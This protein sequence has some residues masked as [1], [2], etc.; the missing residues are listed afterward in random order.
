V[1]TSGV[2]GPGMKNPSLK[3]HNC[4]NQYA[5]L[6]IVGLTEMERLRARDLRT[7]LEVAR[8]LGAVADVDRFRASL[9]LQLKRLVPYDIASWNVVSPG[10]REAQIGAV[11]PADCRENDDE[12]TLGAYLHQNPLVAPADPTQVVKFSDFITLRQLHRLE[13]YDA[14]YRRLAVEHQIAF[15]LPAPRSS[16]I[17]VVLS[18]SRPDFTERDRSILAAAKPIVVQAYEHA[19][20]LAL[21]RGMLSALEHATDAVEHAIIVLHPSGHI[22]FATHAAKAS[23]SELSS[24][25]QPGSLPEPLASWSEAQS[26]RAGAVLPFVESLTFRTGTARFMRG[27]VGG[28]DAIV[29]ERSGQLSAST[30]RA[31]GLTKRQAEVL[32]LVALGLTNTQIALE[33]ALSERTVAKHLEHIYA[34]LGVANRTAA[35]AW[36]RD[37]RAIDERVPPTAP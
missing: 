17:G 20:T 32:A 31:A 7:V 11:D 8:Q 35:V 25:D 12:E 19:V 26:R 27:D 10:S 28:F 34:K 4:C 15:L 1:P 21:M 6:R 24:P 13:L 22:Q 33:L 37:A 14:V 29:I 2:T 5:I 16:V 9:L 36:S 30:L 23:L 18:R 3:V